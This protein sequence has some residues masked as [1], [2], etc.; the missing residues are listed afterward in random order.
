MFNPVLL[1]STPFAFEKACEI[2]RQA[3]ATCAAKVRSEDEGFGAAG[4]HQS[5]GR[6]GLRF[7]PSRRFCQLTM[8]I[9]RGI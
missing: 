1:E 3:G 8:R 7:D 9:E 4:T 2:G 5:W 6:P